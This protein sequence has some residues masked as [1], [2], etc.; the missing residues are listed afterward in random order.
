MNELTFGGLPCPPALVY[1]LHQLREHGIGYRLYGEVPDTDMV[2]VDIDRRVAK[3]LKNSQMPDNWSM[4]SPHYLSQRALEQGRRDPISD[5][6]I[7]PEA[8]VIAFGGKE[9][10]SFEYFQ[11]LCEQVRFLRQMSPSRLIYHS[12]Q[13]PEPMEIHD[14]IKLLQASSS[15]AEG[16][17]DN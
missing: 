5:S 13:P 9:A 1:L 4:I 11:A 15:E 7:I 2:F 14:L 12:R 10:E 3:N 17:A 16:D 8:I 6:N